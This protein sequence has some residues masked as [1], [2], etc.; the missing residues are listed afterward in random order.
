MIY[1]PEVQEQFKKVI[2]YSQG[3]AYDDLKTEELFETWYNSKVGFI[4]IFGDLIYEYPEKVEFKLD[5]QSRKEKIAMML[6]YVYVETAGS[7]LYEFLEDMADC[8]FDNI[9]NKPYDLFNGTVIKKGTKIIKAFK[10]FIDDKSILEEMQN[11][12]SRIIQEDKVCGRLCLSVHPL[13]FLSASENQHK[14][15]SC[16][17]LDGEFRAG[18][19]SYM[20]DDSTIM[21]YLKS[22]KDV[23][24][25]RFPESVPWNNKKWRRWLHFSN[26]KNMLIAGRPYPYSI[27]NIMNF[28]TGTVFP[29]LPHLNSW[30][31]AVWC[32]K[33]IKEINDEKAKVN[34]SFSDTY[35]PVGYELKSLE[36]LAPRVPNNLAYND[37]LDSNFYEPIYAFKPAGWWNGDTGDTNKNTKFLIGHEVKCLVCGEVITDAEHFV[38]E[39]CKYGVKDPYI[40]YCESCGTG[41]REEEDIYVLDSGTRV[42]YDCYRE[43]EQENNDG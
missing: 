1:Y 13:D 40:G 5:E 3:I 21:I 41:F 15:R 8:F 4:K 6:D 29:N 43:I 2:A 39:D 20:L 42:C 12:A 37:I 26:D 32:S 38:C 18:N 34:F 35:I 25:P 14:W 24:L 30:E 11:Y 19:L 27:G 28:I 7:G 31:D 33:L 10:Y 22:D 23:I 9:T 36:A 17:A 16:H